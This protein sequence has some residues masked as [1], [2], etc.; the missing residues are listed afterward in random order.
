MLDRK[1]EDLPKSFCS[2]AWLQIHTEPDGKVF[3][4]C[5]YSHK[6]EHDLGNWNQE[7][8][9]DI[10]HNDKWNNLRK[11]FLDGKRPDACT[12]CWKEEDAGIVSMRNRF[13]ERYANFPDY[14]N[15]NSYNK[16]KDIVSLSNEDGSVDEDIKLATVDLIFNNLCNMKCRTCGPGLSTGWIPDE[17]KL[18]RSKI[19][20]VSLLTNETVIHMKDDLVALVN[21][22]D[23]YTEIHFSGGEPMMQEDHYLFL[24][25]LLD[26]GK[27]KVKLRYNTNLTTFTLKD[28]HAFEML[29]NF[30]NVFMVG[31]CDAMGTEG[32]YI[33][34]G[35][36]WEKAL[37]WIKTC[38]E[39]LPNADYGISAVYSLFNASAAV[40]FHRYMCESELFKRG[41]GKNFGFYLNTLHEPYWMRTTVLPPEVKL[42][43]TE[44]IN[45]H[46]EWLTET[47]EHD[48][49]YDVYIDHWKNAITLMNNKDDTSII[50]KFYV[51]A[52]V[53]DSIRNEKFEEVFPEL[54][55]KMKKYDKQI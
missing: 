31:S 1:I 8:I 11:E 22:V 36:N 25:L 18:G 41:D 48:F 44:K 26:M 32:E 33:R 17:I 3:P 10:F 34:K 50:P 4:C 14:T 2:V 28:Y 6:S 47:Q 46:I 38:K 15:Q 49:H 12:R 20:P 13:N 24:Q 53:L 40:D 30:D 51:E 37:E 21:M 9:V 55:E 43:V 29:K 27:T 7:K 35:F 54:H 5:Y 39:Y 42:E 45:K 23:P 52:H 19:N 16:F